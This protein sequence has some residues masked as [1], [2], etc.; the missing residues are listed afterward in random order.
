MGRLEEL[1]QTQRDR[2]LGYLGRLTGSPEEAEDI[3]HDVFVRLMDGPNLTRPLEEI[4]GLIFAAVR[5]RAWDYYRRRRP[6]N[7]FQDQAPADPACP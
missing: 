7:R 6:R 2:L 3:L 4:V 5:N 1:Y